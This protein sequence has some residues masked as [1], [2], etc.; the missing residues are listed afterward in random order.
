VSQ[1]ISASSR[2]FEVSGG[3]WPEG[4]TAAVLDVTACLASATTA[5]TVVV[6]SPPQNHAQRESLREA[7]RGLIHSSV[8]ERPKIRAN[9]VYGGSQADQDK[10]IK[11]LDGA[12]FVFGATLDLGAS[13]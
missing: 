3:A 7:L 9:L 4:L 11:Y 2:I 13:V 6:R 12:T 5:V 1:I 10:A 8:L